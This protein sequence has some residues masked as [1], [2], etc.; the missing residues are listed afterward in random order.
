MKTQF[1]TETEAEAALAARRCGSLGWCPLIKEDC[2]RKCICYYK[3]DIT[4]SDGNP[5]ESQQFWFVHYPS[6]TNVLIS[7]VITVKS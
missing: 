7:G 6:C 3:G 5:A 4:C 1:E 2:K